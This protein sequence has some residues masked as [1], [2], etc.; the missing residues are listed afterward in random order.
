MQF[1]LLGAILPAGLTIGIS[2]GDSLFLSNVG[3]DKLPYIFILMPVIMV[4]Y[5]SVFSYLINRQGIQRVLSSAVALVTVVAFLLFVLL[6]FR[7]IFS[8]GQLAVL[9]FGIK[10][11]TTVIFIAFFSLYWNFTDLYFDMLEGKRVYAIFA[12]GA[13]LGVMT[14]GFITSV[15]A[16]ILGVNFL[17]LIWTVFGL[18][19]FPV[20]F[21]ITRTYDVVEATGESFEEE[22]SMFRLFGK[23]WNT[24]LKTR[25]VSFIGVMVCLLAL[26]A[27]ISEYQFFEIFSAQFTET[28]LAREL[29]KLYAFVNVFNL[30]ICLFLFNRLVIRFGVTNVALILPTFYILAFAFLLL[31]NSYEAA[32]F[33]F[34][35]YQGVSL[36]IDNNNYNLLFNGLPIQGRAQLRTI[37]EGL[38]EPFAT[39]LAGLFLLFYARRI[40]PE[41]VSLVGFSVSVLLF[42]VVLLANR[43][44]MVSIVQNLKKEWLDFS[45]KLQSLVSRLSS[46]EVEHVEQKLSGDPDEALLAIRIL[47]HTGYPSVLDA[48]LSLLDRFPDQTDAL[49]NRGLKEEIKR[50][51]KSNDYK[52]TTRMITWIESREEMSHF[53]MIELLVSHRLIPTSKVKPLLGSADIRTRGIAITSM[54]ASWNISEVE[55]ALGHIEKLF[56][57]EKVEILTAIRILSYSNNQQYS[58]YLIPH[59]QSDNENIRSAALQSLNEIVNEESTPVVKPVLDILK[60]CRKDDRLLCFNILAKIG[61]P[62]CLVPLLTMSAYF[63]PYE[64]RRVEEIVIGMGTLIVPLLVTVFRE[65]RFLDRSRALAARILYKIAPTQFELIFESIIVDEIRVV[66]KFLSN[67]QLLSTGETTT[68]EMSA[69]SGPM[70]LLK[71]FYLDTRVNKINFILEILTTIGRLPSFELI[72]NSLRS[73]SPKTRSY[74]LEALEQGVNRAIYK[75]LIPLVDGRPLPNTLSMIQDL[76]LK[77]PEHMSEIINVDIQTEYSIEK[78]AVLAAMWETNRTETVPLLRESF[79]ES[80]NELVSHTA[81]ALLDNRNGSYPASTLYTMIRMVQATSFKP[82]NILEIMYLARRSQVRQIPGRETIY[83]RLDESD[84]LY[85][86]IQGKTIETTPGEPDREYLPGDLF[87]DEVIRG[88]TRRTGSLTT[89]GCELIAI[90]RETIESCAGL[91]PSFA[92]HLLLRGL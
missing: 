43:E 30:A 41:A 1:A 62:E 55:D 51:V 82:F 29:G 86:L 16:D 14:G 13:A 22:L 33:I 42:V 70:D 92:I 50:L 40:P 60:V 34:F 61:D 3:V 85:L 69:G 52:V 88:K 75:M 26:L 39:A 2:A 12:G 68:N 21:G 56:R 84:F 54:L 38:F 63:T 79:H 48:T 47:R 89:D 32:V 18:C 11:F 80:D 77:V 24:I 83:N 15:S 91:Y 35:V 23:H 53:D 90:H 87:G 71:R 9:Y 20:L 45:R 67:Y 19:T 4:F 66:Y 72:A 49:I 6:S 81:L 5:A 27:A 59:L 74:A 10:I 17:F 65:N 76:D 7:D 36:S 31:Q 78:A 25:Y 46:G 57:G 37:L 28:E 64:K 44:Y 8:E 58:R 73:T